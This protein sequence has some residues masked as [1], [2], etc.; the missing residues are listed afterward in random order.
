MS[1]TCETVVPEAPPRYSTLLPGLMGMEPMP[2]TIPAPSFE[3]KGFHTRY[4]VFSSGL[5][6]LSA[7]NRFSPYTDSLGAMF[8]VTNE[9]SLP[10]EMK[11]PSWRCFSITTFAAPFLPLPLPPPLA[12]FLPLPLPLSLP[13]PLT[14][15][16]PLSPLPLP[17]FPIAAPRATRHGATQGEGKAGAPRGGDP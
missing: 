10:L 2:P 16:L 9:S 4:S 13:L 6:S 1:E 8:L 11:T 7:I 12:P 5:S 3:R 14:L 17:P 15:P